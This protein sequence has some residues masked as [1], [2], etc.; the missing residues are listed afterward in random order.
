M[1]TKRV[2]LKM[3]NHQFHYFI[4]FFI[5]CRHIYQREKR[6]LIGNHVNK[7]T[8]DLKYDEVLRMDYP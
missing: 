6:V 1:D 5:S 2:K 3:N 8:E 7:S 4:L